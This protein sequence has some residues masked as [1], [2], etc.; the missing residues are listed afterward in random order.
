MV[1][2]FSN[3]ARKARLSEP[4]LHDHN[5]LGLYGHWQTEEYQPPIAVDGKV[6][7][8]LEVGVRVGVRVGCPV[9]HPAT[10]AFQSP[11]VPRNEF[12]NVYLF[13]PSMMPVGC[14]QMTLPNLNR[15]ARKLG[16]DCVQAITGFDFHGG[17]CHPVCVRGLGWQLG[18]LRLVAHTF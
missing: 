3:R 8:A 6:R 7:A 12:G 9:S 2:G 11:Q 13:L 4:Q 5:D 16:I 1:K 17:Y 15:V 10:L 18:R 14:V